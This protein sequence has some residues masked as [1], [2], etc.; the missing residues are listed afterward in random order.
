MGIII[1]RLFANSANERRTRTGLI[2][3]ILFIKF[4]SWHAIYIHFWPGFAKGNAWPLQSHCSK[5]KAVRKRKCRPN[6]SEW[7]PK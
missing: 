2:N 6:Y 7:L 3:L 4:V 5:Q 1:L